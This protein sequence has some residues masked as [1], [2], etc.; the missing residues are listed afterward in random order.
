M[1]E[2][3]VSPDY[4]Q[5]QPDETTPPVILDDVRAAVDKLPAQLRDVINAVYWERIS[6]GEISRRYGI[7]KF[8]VRK[9]ISKGLQLLADSQAVQARN[10]M[11]QVPAG[12]PRPGSVVLP[13]PQD[14]EGDAR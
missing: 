10:P 13:L 12:Q 8:E 7:S 2:P 3:Q 11:G 5:D 6:Q 4:F 1:R 14:R 9:R